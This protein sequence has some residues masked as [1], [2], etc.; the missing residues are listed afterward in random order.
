MLSRIL[1]SVVI[2]ALLGTIGLPAAAQGI[3]DCDWRSSAQNVP[4]P[5]EENTRTFSNGKT[6]VA[7]VDTIEPAGGAY[8]LMV[9]S[10]PYSELGGRQC[11]LLGNGSHGFA[12]LNF[13]ELQASYDVKTG[14][15]FVLP[16]EIYVDGV[17]NTKIVLTVNL[18]Q[19][20]GELMQ[21]ITYHND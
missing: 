21:T 2:S 15:S 17:N 10:P 1:R 16:G 18:N 11:R 7:L 14:L 20:S 13:S 8:W 5:W 3:L 9:L 6:R 4:E 19:S 12:K